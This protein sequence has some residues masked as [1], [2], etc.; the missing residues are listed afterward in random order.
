MSFVYIIKN[1]VNTKVYIG[2]TSLSSIE[3]RFKEHLNDSSKPNLQ[4]SR[5]LYKAMSK[6]GRD[7]FYIELLEDNLTDNQACER[8]SYYIQLYKSYIGFSDCN[9]YNM[10]LGGDGRHWANYKLIIDTYIKNNKNES[11]TAKELSCSRKTIRRACKELGISIK[12]NNKVVKMYD[13]E[14]NLLREFPCIQEAIRY[15][16]QNGIIGASS[17]YQKDVIIK[18]DKIFKVIRE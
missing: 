18:Q 16:K 12:Q 1:Y 14:E 11:K 13:L 4:Q 8:E 17:L 2:K 6:Y 9:G 7:K 15:F 10:T 3:S 5:L